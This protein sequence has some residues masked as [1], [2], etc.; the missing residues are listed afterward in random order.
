MRE[1]IVN[2]VA[3][4]DYTS[5]GSVQVMLFADRL[6]VW[7]P[8]TLSPSLTLQQLREPHGSFPE[9]LARR[10]ALSRQ[11][12]RAHGH[13][14]PRHD[15]PLPEAGLREPQYSIRDGFVHTLW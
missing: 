4:R 12:Y 15:P 11:I 6:E 3:H 7:N 2:A 5:T 10:A 9:P 8:G 14:H 13:R 1:A